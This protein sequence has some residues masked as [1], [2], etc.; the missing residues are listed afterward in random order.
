MQGLVPDGERREAAMRAAA[1]AG[2]QARGYFDPPLHRHPAFAGM[3]CDG[4]LRVTDAIAARSLS[5]PMANELT[6]RE[7]EL[8]AAVVREAVPC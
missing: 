2:V 8:I 3:P 5:L 4:P 7:I 1:R 6:D